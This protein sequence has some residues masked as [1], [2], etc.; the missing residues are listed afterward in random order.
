MKPEE[1][2]DRQDVHSSGAGVAFGGV[3]VEVDC[4]WAAQ[5]AM[6]GKRLMG[7]NEQSAL[8]MPHEACTFGA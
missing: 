4:P 3:A 5:Q 2:G 7:V 8:P 1:T 6:T